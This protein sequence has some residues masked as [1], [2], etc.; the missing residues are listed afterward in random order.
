MLES[1]AGSDIGMERVA[2]GRCDG[3]GS[4]V[5]VGGDSEGSSMDARF[6]VPV[7]WLVRNVKWPLTKEM[8]VGTSCGGDLNQPPNYLVSE[9]LS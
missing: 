7:S 3:T 9:P 1:P 2:L 4:P 5:A 8:D 6:V